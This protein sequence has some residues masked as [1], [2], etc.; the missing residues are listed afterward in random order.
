LAAASSLEKELRGSI[1]GL[2]KTDVA[3]KVGEA[4]AERAKRA[5][6]TRVAFDRSSCGNGAVTSGGSRRGSV[7]SGGREA[8]RNEPEAALPTGW[9]GVC[10]GGAMGEVGTGW[11]GTAV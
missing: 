1:A 6:V 9:T 10:A 7:A 4:L 2:C 11:S 3:P 8:G 5:G